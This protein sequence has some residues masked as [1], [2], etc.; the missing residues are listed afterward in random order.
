MNSCRLET[1]GTP[2]DEN[3]PVARCHLNYQNDNGDF[4]LK[5]LK[6][7]GLPTPTGKK[8]V[9]LYP[10]LKMGSEVHWRVEDYEGK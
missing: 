3:S 8:T 10:E 6:L 7:H 4:D 9:F 2:V 1:A 5:D